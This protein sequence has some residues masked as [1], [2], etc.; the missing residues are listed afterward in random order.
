[1]PERKMGPNFK[2]LVFSKMAV[3]AI[4]NGSGFEAGLEFLCDPKRI[5]ASFRESVLWCDAAIIELRNARDPNPY[6]TASEENICAEL[7]RLVDERKRRN[8]I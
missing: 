4:P 5:G 1:M 7:L 2:K 8:A 6:R 3:D